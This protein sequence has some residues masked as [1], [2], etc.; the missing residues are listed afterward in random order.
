MICVWTMVVRIVRLACY[1]RE[2]C[3]CIS[4]GCETCYSTELYI[5][6][7]GRGREAIILFNIMVRFVYG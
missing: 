7:K 6:Y 5:M 4:K 2:S 1:P 3:I